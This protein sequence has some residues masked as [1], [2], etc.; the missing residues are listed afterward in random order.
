MLLFDAS[1]YPTPFM[2]GILIRKYAKLKQVMLLISCKSLHFFTSDICL[3]NTIYSFSRRDG[4]NVDRK[5]S[6]TQSIK[7]VFFHFVRINVLY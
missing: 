6:R 1:T 3:G 2:H 4:I 7:H 5:F